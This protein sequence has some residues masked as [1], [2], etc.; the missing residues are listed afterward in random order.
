[1]ARYLRY[2]YT[3]RTAVAV[4]IAL[5]LSGSIYWLYTQQIACDA[6]LASCVVSI[7]VHPE[8]RFAPVYD[9]GPDVVIVGID[10]KTMQVLK[11]YPLPRDNYATALAKLQMAGAQAVGFDIGFIDES[12]RD[13]DQRFAKT[14]REATIPVVLSYGGGS[15]EIMNKRL[16]QRGVDEIPLKQFWCGD[17]N[18]DRN[19]ACAQPYPNVVLASTDINLDRDGVLRR[20]PLVVEPRCFAVGTCKSRLIDTFGFAAYRAAAL[21]KDFQGGPDL[22]VSGGVATFGQAWKVPVDSTASVLINFSGPPGNFKNYGHY[23]SFSDLIQGS[24]PL[25]KFKDKIVLIGAYDLTGVNDQQLVTTSFGINQTLPMAGLEIHANVVQMLLGAV[26]PGGSS[27]FLTAEPQWL[28]FMIIL[29][30]ALG[31]ALG[32]SRVS[33]LWGLAGTAVALAAF[34]LAMTSVAAYS[35]YVPDL[36]YPWLALA[37]TYSGVTAYRFLYEDREKRK[38]TALFSV[39]LKPEIVAELTK[40]RGGVEDIM[41]GGIRRDVT[42]LFADIRGF[43]SMSESMEANEVTELVQM[44]LDHLSGIIFK[45]DGTLDK[46]V[47]DEIMAFWNAPRLQGNHALLALRCAY[48]LISQGPELEQR[49]LEKGLPPI[50][51]GIGINSG[52]AVVGMMGSRSRL[53]YTAMGDTVNTAARFCSHAPAFQALI[54]QET[55]DMC[56]DYIAVDLVPGVQ[57]KGKSTERFRIYQV[58]AIRENPT[59]PWVPFPTD[60][61]TQAHHT[62]TT[63]YSQRSVIA[64]GDAPSK[65]ILVGEAAEAALAREPEVL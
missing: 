2:W 7:S 34:T 21:G 16:V 5:A 15:L 45:W 59:S 60:M 47:G 1:L 52:P 53:Q 11:R 40:S 35:N 17:S 38:V 26:A 6:H 57:L 28:V 65:D 12:Q 33:V 18:L 55:Y 62:F 44:Y 63:Q 14:L 30:L 56:K 8:D 58:T 50:R 27:K 25:D 3:Y 54:G 24:V 10:D 20:V 9:P 41:R 19:I 29:A 61:A 46:Y 31:T 48:D 36:F 23:V 22:S 43:T 51:W 49:L 32:V 42:L 64:A 13:S 4:V 39:Y 37:L